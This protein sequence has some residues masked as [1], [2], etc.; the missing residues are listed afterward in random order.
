MIVACIS[1][2]IPNIESNPLTRY[3]RSAI[4]IQ[5]RMLWGFSWFLSLGKRLAN[6]DVLSLMQRW[7]FLEKRAALVDGIS[8]LRQVVGAA[9]SDA[10]LKYILHHLFLQQQAGMR[11]NLTSNYK[12]EMCAANV[13][14]ALLVKRNLFVHLKSTFPKCCDAIDNFDSLEYYACFKGVDVNGA[15]AKS[16]A[17]YEEDDDDDADDDGPSSVQQSRKLLIKFCES[18]AKNRYERT[19][20]KMSKEHYVANSIDLTTPSAKGI[21]SAIKEAKS[22]YVTDFADVAD[23]PSVVVHSTPDTAQQVRVQVV[24]DALDEL[25]YKDKLQRWEQDVTKFEEERCNE[26][27]KHHVLGYVVDNLDDASRAALKVKK[28]MDSCGVGKGVKRKLFVHDDL[29]DKSTDWKKAKKDKKSVF[30]GKSGKLVANDLDPV[31]E[32]YE[33]C[34]ADGDG[35]D[36]IAIVASGPPA[37]SPVDKNVIVAHQRLKNLQP[38][39]Q[40]PKVGTIEISRADIL[41]RVKS[42]HAFIGQNEHHLIFTTQ[43]KAKPQRKSF[44][45]LKGDSYFNKSTY[46]SGAILGRC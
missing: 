28:L 21:W 26:Y 13:S 19:L 4:A 37:N 44:S 22:F 32:I 12:N 35:D 38:K 31:V 2:E 14:K 10:D 1:Y 40:K 23:A 17:D 7:E 5:N 43:S 24:A 27:L 30:H 36:V 15:R 41:Q 42:K 11:T 3:G 18:L 33:T 20:I 34:K 39:H 25:S 46:Q 45:V 6:K 8:I 16:D 9:S 29:C